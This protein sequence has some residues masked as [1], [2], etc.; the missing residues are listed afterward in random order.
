MAN[1]RQEYSAKYQSDNYQIIAL[2]FNKV[3]DCKILDH[4]YRIKNK[5]DYVRKL[6][7]DDMSSA[8]YDNNL[9]R[10]EEGTSV[11]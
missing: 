7:N 3:K 10:D 5:T 8:G 1:K 9:M 2:H 4:L 6:I 11:L